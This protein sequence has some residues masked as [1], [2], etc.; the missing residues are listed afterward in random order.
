MIS[1]EAQY[2]LEGGCA[3]KAVRY[4]IQTAPLFVHCCHC[5]WCQRET[6]SAFA[7]NILIEADRVTLLQEEKND[8]ELEVVNAPSQS[9]AGQKISRCKKCHVA[10]WSTYG[11]L[12]P[13]VQFVRA[14]TLDQAFLV[15][16]DVHI[17]T[18]TKVPWLTFPDNVPVFEAFYGLEQEWP[19]ESLARR[20]AFMPVE[21]DRRQSAS[22][23]Q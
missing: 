18:N 8:P 3:C 20:K 13:V 21:E 22:R 12:G 15:S 11:G 10:V 23:K 2:P 5:T 19:E 14:G 17:Y 16:P 6:G 7:I 1:Q 9:G 4:Q